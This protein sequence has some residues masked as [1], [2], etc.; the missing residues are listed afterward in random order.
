LSSKDGAVDI[1]IGQL[2]ESAADLL[3][4]AFI[5]QA[6]QGRVA[7]VTP[8]ASKSRPRAMPR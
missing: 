8:A 7:R 6:L 3:K 4:N 5:A 1:R 2:V